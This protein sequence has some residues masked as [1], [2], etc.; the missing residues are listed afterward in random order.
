MGLLGKLVSLAKDSD[1]ST[2]IE[3]I[4]P[5][6]ECSPDD[7]DYCD[8]KYPSSMSIDKDTPLWNN[9]AVWALQILIATGKNDWVHD[10]TSVEGSLAAALSKHS[11]LLEEK[12][13]GK[14]KINTC[15]AAPPDEHQIRVFSWQIL[16]LP[17]FIYISLTSPAT[18]VDDV[19]AAINGFKNRS[20][21][22][23]SPSYHGE[24]GLH[25]IPSKQARLAPCRNK[26]FVLLCSHRTRDKR[27]GITGPILKKLFDVRFRQEDLYRDAHD[28]RPGG[29]EAL[30][31]SHVG[32]HKFNANVMVYLKSG[33]SLWM[34]RVQPQH[35]GPIVDKTIMEGK[36]FPT[37]MRQAMKGESLPW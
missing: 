36:A 32:G 13:G 6:A 3:K 27:C 11:R 34:G 18:V 5:L 16:L 2:A 17:Y 22:W 12:A 33:E 35:V 31:I 37:L 1:P 30:Y 23:M 14:V 24:S 28:D 26:G 19:L 8:T 4:V 7:C 21:P 25:K 15:S 10:V 20:L 9:V 29:V